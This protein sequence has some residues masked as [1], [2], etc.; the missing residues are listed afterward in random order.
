MQTELVKRK[1]TKVKRQKYT[2]LA[3]LTGDRINE[4]LFT[5]KRMVVY[6]GG[7]KGVAEITR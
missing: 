7:L 3:E 6:P 2:N 1:L 5:R 4:G